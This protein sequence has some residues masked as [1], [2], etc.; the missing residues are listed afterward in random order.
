MPSTFMRV[1][2]AEQIAEQYKRR[3]PIV[4][5]RYHIDDICFRLAQTRTDC[6]AFVRAVQTLRATGDLEGKEKQVKLK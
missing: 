6:V 4:T 3:D 5:D 1:Y 2:T